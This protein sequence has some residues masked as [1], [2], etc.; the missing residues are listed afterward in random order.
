MFVRT[1]ENLVGVSLVEDRGVSVVIGTDGLSR[2]KVGNSGVREKKRR[3]LCGS[4]PSKNKKIADGS[5]GKT[6][7]GV[8]VSLVRD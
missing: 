7:D 8:G 6:Q 5:V 1:S 3:G 4:A 2:E